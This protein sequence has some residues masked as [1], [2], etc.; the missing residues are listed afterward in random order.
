MPAGQLYINGTGDSHDAYLQYGVSLSDT[1]IANLMAPPSMKED[2]VN[3]SRL[4]HGT[5][6]TSVGNKMQQREL[7]LPVHLVAKS[8]SDYL[9]KYAAFLA[10]LQGVSL[11]LRTSFQPGVVYR[12]RYVSCTQFTQYINGMAKLML[13]LVEPNP[14][15]RA[16]QTQTPQS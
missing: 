15:N 9:T 13:R 12:V 1:A 8:Q 6:H 4:E 5:R 10:V 2:I 7:S 11:T 14:S 16:E 3:E